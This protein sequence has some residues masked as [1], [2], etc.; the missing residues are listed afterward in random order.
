MILQ[1]P[2]RSWCTP[3]PSLWSRLGTYRWICSD[4]RIESRIDHNLMGHLRELDD[5][6]DGRA[7][8]QVADDGRRHPQVKVAPVEADQWHHRVGTH[9]G[10]QII[11]GA[12]WVQNLIWRKKTTK[13]RWKNASLAST[14]TTFGVERSN[15]LSMARQ[16]KFLSQVLHCSQYLPTEQPEAARSSRHFHRKFDTSTT[17]SSDG[18]W[19]Q[20][21]WQWLGGR[22]RWNKNDHLRQ[23]LIAEDDGEAER[24]QGAANHRKERLEED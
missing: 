2:P 4:N 9:G 16:N 17:S 24:R 22:L 19:K 18:I 14:V 13:N 15:I 8:R 3:R 21:S 5:G 12:E 20:W 7:E 1:N 10:Q 23:V 6:V 11:L